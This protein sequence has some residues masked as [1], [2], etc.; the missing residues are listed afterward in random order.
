MMELPVPGSSRQQP[1]QPTMPRQLIS[2]QLGPDWSF[3]K[4][5]YPPPGCRLVVTG[6]YTMTPQPVLGQVRSGELAYRTLDFSPCVNNGPALA[7]EA[8]RPPKMRP[9]A[10]VVRPALNDRFGPHGCLPPHV[11]SCGDHKRG[12]PGPSMG[13]H[14]H[15]PLGKVGRPAIR[16]RGCRAAPLPGMK[17]LIPVAEA[18]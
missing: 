2:H 4:V 16:D 12:R 14:P 18:G 13:S 9:S 3:A 5:T 7:G 1:V 10:P 15:G 11:E 17:P 6:M 8:A